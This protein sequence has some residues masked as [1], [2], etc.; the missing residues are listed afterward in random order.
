MKQLGHMITSFQSMRPTLSSLLV[1]FLVLLPDLTR[2]CCCTLIGTFTLPC[3]CNIFGCNCDTD[4]G[5][6]YKYYDHDAVCKSSK[7]RKEEEFCPDR[8]R[9]RSADTLK[10]YGGIYDHDLI[11]CDAMGYFLSFDLN[12]DGLISLEEAM[13][14]SRSSSNS[15]SF[16]DEFKK[17]DVDNDGFVRPS[18]FDISL[19]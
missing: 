13:K 18:E 9:R 16:L 11:E 19:V 3:R 7:G 12:R 4:N 1:V 10:A 2:S 8:R 17:V 6:C 5:W 15:S 14:T